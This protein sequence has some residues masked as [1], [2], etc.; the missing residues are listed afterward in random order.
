LQLILIIFHKAILFIYK[1]WNFRGVLTSIPGPSAWILVEKGR[2]GTGSSW[3]TSFSSLPVII[4][5]AFLVQ[6]SYWS[7]TGS[8]GTYSRHLL[9]SCHSRYWTLRVSAGIL[10]DGLVKKA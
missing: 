9:P 2:T 7:V 1:A 5:A 3:L 8:S 10:P 4:E 6:I